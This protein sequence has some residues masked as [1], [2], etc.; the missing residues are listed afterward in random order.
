MGEAYLPN[1][2][3]QSI[4]GKM[5][6]LNN[7]N[8][9]P[10]DLM[11]SNPIEKVE[12]IPSEI[13]GTVNM[14]IVPNEFY[15]DGVPGLGEEVDANGNNPVPQHVAGVGIGLGR[16][17]VM[18]RSAMYAKINTT[19]Q[20]VARLENRQLSELSEIKRD[21]RGLREQ[22]RAIAVAPARR[23][24]PTAAEAAPV[25]VRVGRRDDGPIRR[26]VLGRCPRTIAV[27]WDE[28]QNGLS[29]NKP[30]SLFTR[31]ERGG[32]NKHK[33]CRRKVVWTTIQRLMDDRG[34]SLQSAIA[35]IT[36]A[37]GDI[38]VTETI[39]LMKRDERNGGHPLLR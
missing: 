32:R 12:V 13:D 9:N 26:A 28:W 15:Q 22:V 25:R 33:Y 23:G 5:I 30:A 14:D 24:G 37:Y 39:N 11:N 18:W 35:R 16:H 6:I 7:D 20:V 21:I 29:G 8:G 2:L 19:N 36:R 17:S 3:Q 27:L 34:F 38:S 31:S 4:T 1:S 10:I